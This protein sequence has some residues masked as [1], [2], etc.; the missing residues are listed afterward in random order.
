MKNEILILTHESNIRPIECFT[1]LQND[2]QNIA[3]WIFSWYE[4]EKEKK[5]DC[6]TYGFFPDDFVSLENNEDKIKEF[7]QI[8]PKE[9]MIDIPIIEFIEFIKDSSS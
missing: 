2:K 6:L 7:L 4:N 5:S 8:K 9:N 3:S 1:W